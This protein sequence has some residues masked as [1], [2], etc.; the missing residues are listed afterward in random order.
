MKASAQTEP[1]INQ[2]QL[3]CSKGKVMV[4]PG[5]IFVQINMKQVFLY[6]MIRSLY[7]AYISYVQGFFLFGLFFKPFLSSSHLYQLLGTL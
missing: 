3:H 1:G 7:M 2:K 4:I 6:G 5:E